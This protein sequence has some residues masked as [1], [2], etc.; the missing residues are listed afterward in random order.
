MNIQVLKITDQD[1]QF[2]DD[3]YYTIK[4]L[5]EQVLNE[6]YDEWYPDED[7]QP[8]QTKEEI[9][10]DDE[11]LY[12]FMNERGFNI[13]FIITITE[14]EI[15]KKTNVIEVGISYYHPDDDETKKVYDIEGMTEEFENKLKQLI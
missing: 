10:T 4:G 15:P 2:A 8:E 3:M 9:E 7:N 12:D 14:D 13:E 1:D 5:R 11:K 6:W